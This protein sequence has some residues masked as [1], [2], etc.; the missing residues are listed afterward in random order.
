MENVVAAC[1]YFDVLIP[2]WDQGHLINHMLWTEQCNR[3]EE[4]GDESSM[5][6]TSLLAP[7]DNNNQAAAVAKTNGK[8]RFAAH[9]AAEKV[10]ACLAKCYFQCKNLLPWKYYK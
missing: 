3:E 2:S 5:E 6:S 4:L 1:K 9:T 8:S 7:N 10:C